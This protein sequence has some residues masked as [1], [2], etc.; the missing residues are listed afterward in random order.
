[1]FQWDQKLEIIWNILQYMKW[2]SSY[3]EYT[4]NSIWFYVSL[5]QK[6]E[7]ASILIRFAQKTHK[8]DSTVPSRIRY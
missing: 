2:T 3:G 1:M 8:L 6:T 5:K 7:P 4:T